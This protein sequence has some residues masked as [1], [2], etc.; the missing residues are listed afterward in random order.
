[1]RGSLIWLAACMRA[2]GRSWKLLR[3]FDFVQR[4]QMHQA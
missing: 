3:S 2:G 1:M 4:A